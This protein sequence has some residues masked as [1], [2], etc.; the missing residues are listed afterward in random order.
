MDSKASWDHF[1]AKT[2]LQIICHLKLFGIGKGGHDRGEKN[3]RVLPYYLPDKIF[4]K[5]ISSWCITLPLGEL[6]KSSLQDLT[7]LLTVELI[8]LSSL[9]DM[10]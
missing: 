1:A 4:T 10:S 2:W 5:I 6:K 8:N 7:S 9:R 3:S